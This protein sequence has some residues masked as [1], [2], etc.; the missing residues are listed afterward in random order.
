MP[1]VSVC[2]SMAM[3]ACCFLGFLIK[4]LLD[5]WNA[6]ALLFVMRP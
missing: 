2:V 3:S 6:G 4:R 5:V 1:Y